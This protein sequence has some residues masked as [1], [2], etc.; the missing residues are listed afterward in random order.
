[1]FVQ[2]ASFSLLTQYVLVHSIHHRTK[3]WVQ[4]PSLRLRI[5]YCKRKL[6]RARIIFGRSIDRTRGQVTVREKAKSTQNGGIILQSEEII[7]ANLGLTFDGMRIIESGYALS[8]TLATM[9]RTAMSMVHQYK[10]KK[11]NLLR[12]NA[13]FM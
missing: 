12:W 13:L 9:C 1:M 3:Q 11:T 10:A 5:F 8:A 4:Y 2:M 7:F 6:L